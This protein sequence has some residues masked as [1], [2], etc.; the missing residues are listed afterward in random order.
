[1][2]KDPIEFY[3]VKHR[4]KIKVPRENC[5]LETIQTRRGERTRIV[6]LVRDNPT[7]PERKVSKLCSKD[8]RL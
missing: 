7:G 1:M 4:R 6:G 3:D 5:E 8:F 2:A